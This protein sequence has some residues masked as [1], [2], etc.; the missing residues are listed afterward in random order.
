MEPAGRD[1]VTELRRLGSGGRED[2][3]SFRLVLS[4]LWRCLPHIQGVRRHLVALAGSASLAILILIPFVMM[5]LNVFWTG[6]LQGEP[7]PEIQ[8]R[9]FGVDPARVA[10]VD[11]IA[12]DARR[13]LFDRGI[14]VAVPFLLLFVLPLAGLLVYY[15]IW[16]TQQ[17]NQSLRMEL[18]DRLQTLSLRFHSEHRVGDAIYRLFQDSA[19]VSDLI[20]ALFLTPV[21]QLGRHAITT[22]IVWMIH[23]LVGLIYLVAW[24]PMLALG[25]W[26]SRRM[27]VGFRAARETNAALTARIQ[28]IL[29]GIK[30]V[31]AY[32]IEAREQ[33]S[34]ET[35]SR[36]AFDAAFGVRYLVSLF[37]VVTF[38]V[39][40][41][42]MLVAGG[43]GIEF[44]RTGA[45]IFAAFA[46]GLFGFDRWT[47]GLFNFF[48]GEMGSGAT[49]FRVTFRM[50]ARV[51]DMAIGIDRVFQLL[52][53]EPEVQDAPD[54]VPFPDLGQGVAFESVS[55]RYQPDR[56]VLE[57]VDFRAAPGT[58]TA[59]V[60]PTGSGK[61]TLMAL[62]L[63][64]FDPD[65]GSVRIGSEDVR[66]IRLAELREK[67]AIALQENVLFGTSVRENIRYAVPESD[68]EA[69][70]AAARVAC[71]DG[72][73]SALPEGYETMLGERGA[74][75]STGQRQRLSIARAILK[76]APILVLDE[77]TAAL[78]ASTELE[79]MDNLHEWARGRCV[80]VITHRLSTIRRA[81]QILVLEEGR[82]AEHGSHAELLARDGGVYRRLVEH[83]APEPAQ[84]AAR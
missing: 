11:A 48:K 80:F 13:L 20:E 19:M 39:V 3:L 60:G 32:G 84:V 38:V 18:H 12:P 71:A 49:A 77:P 15:Y 2:R 33:A 17:I 73:V 66:R 63:R 31:K 59:V 30:V 9:V 65:S 25:G 61:S 52:D 6:I 43:V 8:A 53:L 75:L 40:C 74:K 22:A 69:V 42:A 57:G 81:D 23:P 35:H 58:V 26:F 50:W 70:R 78:D 5:S 56:P 27:R 41:I 24:I 14:R 47:L 7:I 46:L 67:V 44:T 34:F 82:L 68:D 55:F 76:D 45:A 83:E 1:T 29:A 10:Y 4:I 51:Q 36:A 79:V 16:I 62:L 37:S 54:A 21:F 64:L 72:F 28:E